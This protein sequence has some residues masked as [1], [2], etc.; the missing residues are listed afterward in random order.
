MFRNFYQAFIFSL[1]FRESSQCLSRMLTA[2]VNCFH[3]LGLAGEVRED[4]TFL[5]RD[6]IYL[7]CLCIVLVSLGSKKLSWDRLQSS[8]LHRPASW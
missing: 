7:K 6:Y 3:P 8:L 1:S 2:A 4:V 5:V